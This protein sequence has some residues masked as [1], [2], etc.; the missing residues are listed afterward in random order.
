MEAFVVGESLGGFLADSF[1]VK[2]LFLGLLAS[3]HVWIV[4]G[5]KKIKV[6]SGG[7]CG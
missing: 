4:L 5:M 2:I 6:S 7:G 1:A 3:D